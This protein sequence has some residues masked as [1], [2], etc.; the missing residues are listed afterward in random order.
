[1]LGFNCIAADSDEEAELLASSV[2]QAFVNLRS[3][4]PSKLP[5]PRPAYLRSL[6]PSARA[7][8][9]QLLACSAIGSVRTVRAKV[10]E[11]AERTGADELMVT[12]QIHDPAAR[13]RSYELL[14]EAVGVTTRDQALV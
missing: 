7:L 4:R 13:V 14:R 3:G 9:D 6:A 1:M 5:A 8:L 2:Q 10:E 12:A 11:F